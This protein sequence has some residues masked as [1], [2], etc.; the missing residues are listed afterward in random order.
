MTIYCY[1][2]YYKLY[3]DI[4]LIKMTLYYMYIMCTVHKIKYF[5]QLYYAGVE[6]GLLFGAGH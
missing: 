5:K 4:K 2:C 6:P 1:I 3:Y